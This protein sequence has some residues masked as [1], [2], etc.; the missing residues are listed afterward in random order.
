MCPPG[1]DQTCRGGQQ[2]S[3]MVP[4]LKEQYTLTEV[5][6]P[7]YSYRQSLQ[8][9]KE[10]FTWDAFDTLARPSNFNTV[11]LTE[12]LNRMRLTHPQST[13]AS[14]IE[15]LPPELLTMVLSALSTNDV[16]AFGLASQSLW[17]H[18]L[19][20]VQQQR[21]K[22]SWAGRPL[23]C[24]G[25]YLMSVPPA[26][27]ALEP[28]LRAQEEEFFNAA[29]S[30]PGMG[31]SRRGMC[32]ARRWNWNA[33]S[34]F[35]DRSTQ[36]LESEWVNSFIST[37][38]NSGIYP[39][40]IATLR[41]TLEAM[42]PRRSRVSKRMRD[43]R[44][45]DPAKRARCGQ[46]NT[47]PYSWLLRNLTTHEYVVLKQSKR[48]QREPNYMHVKG[49]PSLSVDKAL[50]MRVTWSAEYTGKYADEDDRAGDHH[51]GS[52]TL[53]ERTLKRGIWAGHCFEI[54]HVRDD[55]IGEEWRDVTQQFRSPLKATKAEL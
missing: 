31:M 15:R 39:V 6:A 20:H 21:Q 46:R 19:A 13:T 29:P 43:L 51:D 41:H 2:W 17:M 16:V 33:R 28:E 10:E 37:S 53:A 45:A 24:T 42:L 26:I 38:T 9:L 1:V 55:A 7:P 22:L 11:D 32:P 3:L 47:T 12:L 36:P 23:L 50:L 48:Y 30:R 40:D 35:T 52:E 25:T 34:S 18:L 14:A 54:V 5:M 49:L 8:F 4:H 27:H 44:R